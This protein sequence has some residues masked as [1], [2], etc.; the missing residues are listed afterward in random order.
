[1]VRPLRRRRELGG[2]RNDLARQFSAAF[3]ASLLGFACVGLLDADSAHATPS[4]AWT[5]VGILLGVLMPTGA[6]SFIAPVIATV[7]NVLNKHVG[8]LCATFTEVG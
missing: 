3:F 5:S 8:F 4:T 2:T 6:V 7:F 1:M